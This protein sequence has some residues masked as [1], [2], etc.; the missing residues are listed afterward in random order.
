MTDHF[1][2]P[3]PSPK[4]HAAAATII[5]DT[6]DQ[7]GGFD[8]GGDALRAAYAI[9]LPAIVRAEVERFSKHLTN[10]YADKVMD[11]YLAARFG[12]REKNATTCAIHGGPYK[13]CPVCRPAPSAVASPFGISQAEEELKRTKQEN[14]R[15][16]DWL[17]RSQARVRELLTVTY[18]PAERAFLRA[19]AQE[20]VAQARYI[21]DSLAMAA[22]ALLAEGE[23]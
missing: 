22:R 2:V 8:A 6:V 18:T 9:D 17:D 13:D 10:G 3:E 4:A 19:L 20:R 16:K 11:A 1:E 5:N 12:E 15:L 21:P 7:L 23:K 14:Q